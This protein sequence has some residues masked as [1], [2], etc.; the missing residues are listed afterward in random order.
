MA[1]LDVGGETSGEAAVG[2]EADTFEVCPF[3]GGHG[4]E[5]SLEVGEEAELND[6]CLCVLFPKGGIG[7]VLPTDDAGAAKVIQCHVIL[8]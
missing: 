6:R 5:V 3:A 8:R 7:S 2:S 1:V 4:R